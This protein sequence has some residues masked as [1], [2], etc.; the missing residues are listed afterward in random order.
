MHRYWFG[1]IYFDSMQA[2]ECFSVYFSVSQNRILLLKYMNVL[3]IGNA[4]RRYRYS[5]I[6]IFTLLVSIVGAADTTA[7][8]TD[9]ISVPSPDSTTPLDTAFRCT[10]II[11]TD[12]S[13]AII[14][15]DGAV[16][17]TTPLSIPDIKKG[18][19]TLLIKKRGYYQK[20]AQIAIS[21]SGIKKLA[22]SL[23]QPGG[24]ALSSDPPGASIQLNGDSVG[25]TPFRTTTLK[26]G[27]YRIRFS[28][29]NRVS[30]D[31][32]VAVQEGTI[33]TIS[34]RLDYDQHY[35]DSV[36]QAEKAQNRVKKYSGI[37]L[38]AGLFAAFALMVLVI[39]LQA[40]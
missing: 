34:V 10:L 4:M 32:T 19:H 24:L 5:L 39:E 18:R 12:P 16:A 15:L 20:K 1:K 17:G 40:R 38:V 31:T 6:I 9:S 26:A 36:V 27:D 23:S 11:E 14:E 22:L 3:F 8:S 29:E 7:E 2:G 35:L 33:D 30:E 37:I 21:E 28:L 25:T 13:N